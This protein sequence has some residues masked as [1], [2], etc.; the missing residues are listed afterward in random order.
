[1]NKKGVKKRCEKLLREVKRKKN[2]IVK[3]VKKDVIKK[4]VLI[5][6]KEWKTVWIK[7]MWK[8]FDKIKII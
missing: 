7:K 8:R 3:G 6:K 2:V 4:T 5:K 1:M